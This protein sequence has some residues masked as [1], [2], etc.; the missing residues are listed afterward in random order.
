MV[1]GTMPSAL[2]C[3][4]AAAVLMA[5]NEFWSAVLRVPGLLLKAVIWALRLAMSVEMASRSELTLANA[6]WTTAVNEAMVVIMVSNWFL[7]WR[8][9]AAT[10]SSRR[11]RR[12]R[13]LWSL[14]FTGATMAEVGAGGNQVFPYFV[15]VVVRGLLCG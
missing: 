11:V 1:G 9:S 15:I 2:A 10:A 3:K 4:A 7:D 5:S 13:V 14:S 8:P 6:V 12:W